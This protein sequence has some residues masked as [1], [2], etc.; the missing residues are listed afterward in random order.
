MPKL[1]QDDK[2]AGGALWPGRA[3]PGAGAR[4]PGRSSGPG[5]GA[6]AARE[7]GKGASGDH[8]LEE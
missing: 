2:K 3:A 8:G 5:G 6:R 7:L 1:R 4:R